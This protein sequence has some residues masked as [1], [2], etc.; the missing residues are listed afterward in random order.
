VG[1]TDKQHQKQ[2]G[3]GNTERTDLR[4]K[5]LPT[6][7]QQ[8]SFLRGAEEIKPSVFSITQQIIDEI[9]TIGGNE[10]NSA[11]RIV[12]YFKKNYSAQDNA[13][14]LQKEYAIG[15]KGFI[16]GEN[17][18]SAL[19]NEN[20]LHIAAGDTARNN[21]NATII[22]W[23]Q[24]AKRI[25]E[26]LDTGRYLP[27]S[28]LDKA[29]GAEIKNL[30]ENL[31]EIHHNRSDGAEF[32]F[33]GEELFDGGFSGSTARI[34][35][36][37]RKPEQRSIILDGLTEFAAAYKQDKTLLR[38]SY[39][40]RYLRGAITTLT[41]LQREP[42]VFTAEESVTVARPGFITQDEVDGLLT[43]GGSIEHSKYR[44][45]A[46]FLESHTAKEKADFLRREYG[47]GGFG[48]TGENEWHDSKGIT[49]SRKIG[50]KPYDSILL[51]WSKVAERTSEL[52]TGGRYMTEQELAYIPEYEKGELARNIVSFYPQKPE[53]LPRPFPYGTD[54]Y[55]SVEIVRPQLDDPERVTKIL[56]QMAQI[57]DNTADFDERYEFMQKTFADLTAYSNGEYSLFANKPAEKEQGTFAAPHAAITQKSPVIPADE[58]A[59]YEIQLGTV[60]WLGPG[61]YE[62]I[63]FDDNTVVLRD[64]KAP[65]LTREIP[66]GEFDRKLRENNLNDELIKTIAPEAPPTETGD[67]HRV[68]YKK[69]MPKLTDEILRDGTMYAILRET[70]TEEDEAKEAVAKWLDEFAASETAGIE[71]PGLAD[72]Y[73]LPKFRD[74]LIEDILD[75]TYQDVIYDERDRV[76]R[77]E[78]DNNTPDWAKPS[79][80]NEQVDG[81]LSLRGFTVS[82]ELIESGID[83]SG[84]NGNFQDTA[85]YTKSEYRSED[86]EEQL[87]AERQQVATEESITP[88][89]E[90]SK[91]RGHANQFDPHPEIPQEQRHNY[92]I[93][94]DNLGAGSGKTKYRYNVEAI[95][96]LQKIESENRFATPEEQEILAKYVG[97]G[98]ISQAFDS[99]HKD[100]ASEYA[101]LKS[102]LNPEEYASAKASTLNAHYTSPT[103]IKAIYKA[104]EN[105]GF[106]TGNVLEPSCGIGNFFGLVPESME[107]SKLFGV[108]LDSITGRIAR[109]LYQKSS[110]A[111]QGFETAELPDSFFDLV[112]GNVPFGEYKVSDKRYD[113]HNFLIHDYFFARALDKVRPGG[114]VAFVTSKGTLDKQN[115]AVRKYIAQRADLLGAVRLPNTAFKSNAGTEVTADIIF[116][117]KRDRIIDVE[118]D[119]V[120]LGKTGDGV[121]VNSY[122]A[123]HPDMVLGEMAFSKNMYG[124]AKDTTCNPLP[125]AELSEQLDEA[126]TNIRAEITDYELGDDEPEEDG[127]I[128]ADPRVRNF[129]Y[130][131]V[132]GQIYY[133]QDSIMVPVEFPVTTQS[134]VKGMIEL[135]ECVRNLIM[136]QTD[137]Y[138]EH[139]IKSEQVK[140]NKLYDNF[141]KKYGLINSRGN[142][143]AFA[144][145]GSYPLLCSLEVLDENGKL[146][147]KADM[148]TKRTIRP[149]IPI[150]H[151]DTASEALAVSLSEKARVDLSF[152]A[153]LTNM[154]GE[155]IAKELE[156]VI[157]LN[158]GSA[159]SQDKTYVTADEYLS[160]N[161]REKL[162]LAKAAQQALP[163]GRY[164]VNV[165]ALEAVLPED[166]TAGEISVRLGATW[167][168]EDVVQQFV[169]ELMQTPHYAKS[170]VKVRYSGYTG[171]WN[172]AE[173]SYD[174]TNIHA[175][176][177]YGT[178]RVSAYKIIEQSLNLRDVRVWDKIYVGG[179]EKRVLN[180]KET[181]IAQGKQEIIRAKFEE[182]IW[183][184]P[185]RRKRL[186]RIYNDTFNSI[187]PREYDGSHLTFPGMNP[188]I[189]LRKHQVDAI[190]RI[191]YG[192]NALLAHEVGAGK[193]YAMAGAA[194]ESRRLGLAS[195]NLIVVPN[196][197]TGQWASEWLQLYPSAN[198][199][200][201]TKRDFEKSN[202]KKFCARIAT[203]DYD[204]VIMG[205]SQFEKIP[206]S[207]ARQEEMLK[208][209]I[210]EIT[211]GIK[212]LKRNNGERFTV[213]Q[214]VR[215][216]KSLEVKLAKLNDRERK[217]DVVTFEELGIDKLFI[218]E[219]H[220][221]K[222]LFLT[223]KMRNVG[224]IAQTEAQKSSD[225]FMKTQYLDELKGGRGTVFATGTPISNSMVELYTMQRYL[226]YAELVK[227]GLQ[228]FD[229]WA[230]TFGE[231][232]TAIEL[233]PEGTGYR[234]KTR[235]AKFYNLPELMSMFRQ[236]ADI[237]T[238][239]MLDLP[240][241]KANFHNIVIKPSDWQRNMVAELAERAEHIRDRRVD[242]R[243]DNMLKVTND[244][245][246]LALDQRLINPLLPDEKVGKVS[247]CADNVFSIWED[248][249]EKRLTQLVF[250]D[251]STPKPADKETG[252]RAFNVYD[253]MKEKLIAKGIPENEIAF[254]HDA[255]TEVRKKELFAK[256]RAGKIRVLIGSTQKMGA[257]TN[258][259]DKLIALHDVDCPWRPSDLEQRLGRIVRQGNGNPEVEIF[260]YVTEGT[261]DSY[262]YQLVEGKQKFIAQIMTG[263]TPVRIAEDV[264]ETALSYAEIKAL[265]TGNPLII[266]KCQL[267]MDVN[268]LKILRASHLS[269]KYAL[270]DKILKE[271][272]RDIK[273]L[274]ERIAGYMADTETVTANP[275]SKESFPTMKIGENFYAK[276]TDAG[277]AIISACKAMTSPD[278]M[279]LGEYRGFSMIL[280]FDSFSKDYRVILSGALSHT[281]TLGSDMLGNITRLDNALE[282][283]ADK[284][285]NCETKL[286][287]VQ[288]QLDTAKAE[289][290]RPFNQE[291]EYR[292]KS[293]RL[294]EVNSLLNM[295]EKDNSVMD[296]EPDEADELPLQKVAGLER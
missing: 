230:A 122:F 16:F 99:E 228:H 73:V 159:E 220:Y 253:D 13:A 170:R 266:E 101:E 46:Y 257:G 218:D 286:A 201:A 185:E 153:Q 93:E 186:C 151:V 85:D 203:G 95:R 222:N 112:V 84:E 68:L 154:S 296:I 147:R 77:H 104:A 260:R 275:A 92:R 189:A 125:G 21:N 162:A 97:F 103:V 272:P 58:N 8:L 199:L 118:P 295:D 144:Q 240:V 111:V 75:C 35:E 56:S 121:P 61:E 33:L 140:L 200:V 193:T 282:G 219:A 195:K 52:I 225:L 155:D 274:T 244:G 10:E 277:K 258:V 166:L 269:Q 292:Q 205:H 198:I 264:D 25:R 279:P 1:G 289:V 36:L 26:L 184:D 256:V 96:T 161:I 178:Q 235:F 78:T 130:T 254:I 158:I 131:L 276:K 285:E 19:F 45:Y 221:F 105:M 232:L 209:Q 18:V 98:G 237:Q 116:L 79:E 70:E 38:F 273:Q 290:N 120:H 194:M 238:A 55:M 48:R 208:K 74:W 62:I 165:S 262:L 136:Y 210:G 129:S 148:F 71:Y 217:D 245:R 86:A 143:I 267:E 142:S 169:Y 64:V 69:Y 149:H 67:T 152:M 132:D 42:L 5:P 288:L 49:Y 247:A 270:E 43:R 268:K 94:N 265:A 57:L 206:M 163:D 180:K 251:L 250:C 6:E 17:H 248:N 139:A 80:F 263:K 229:A 234:S 146:E 236:V 179:N 281:V 252:E 294:K 280:S 39:S 226:Q 293:A 37:V 91:P 115:P 29:D 3:G 160:G 192:G 283:F 109:Q 177:T 141:T 123:E 44:I 204:A 215:V 65:L 227:Y 174:R 14:F 4:I 182:W 212:E 53:E 259:Q 20:G 291:L 2:R 63:S 156:G 175:T 7:A 164:D 214:M 117:Q 150:A 54:F 224:G 197:I 187:R 15:G 183:E 27:Q 107:N 81:E 145:D 60:V 239:D 30:A 241:P 242:P 261:F 167:V 249:K 223:T 88:A 89:R 59:E 190:A 41:D 211:D 76:T 284:R 28:E 22:T 24:A 100:W 133:R 83:E 9:L 171:E 23:E 31:W 34:A 127:V 124:N 119:W 173:K 196:H 72:A 216:Q 213:K 157:F 110:I 202:R 191:L 246:K 87:P 207:I 176:N 188:E 11:L 271:Y 172:I 51:P 106:R 287:E 40:A 137:D 90:Q 102:L 138:P 108:E 126:V 278:P 255:D 168:P 113:K 135:R 82:D 134:R 128:P 243:T 66:K 231:T 12:S 181:A 233:A 50:N 47:D 32:P 114:I